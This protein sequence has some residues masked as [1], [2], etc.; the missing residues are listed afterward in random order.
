MHPREAR[1]EREKAMGRKVKEESAGE[2]PDEMSA[3]H[4]QVAEPQM[5]GGALGVLPSDAK[6]TIGGPEV[7]PS[8]QVFEPPVTKRFRVVQTARVNLAGGI[9]HLHAGQTIDETNYDIQ[10][11]L[12][13]GVEL[14]EV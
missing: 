4:A 5:T 3:E 2:S 11:L 12:N 1:G 6:T 13:A 14:R 9:T 8:N 10:G 7:A